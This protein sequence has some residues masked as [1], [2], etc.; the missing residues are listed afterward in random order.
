MPSPK[1]GSVVYTEPRA[2]RV[3]GKYI[4]GIDDTEPH[5][6]VHGS[7]SIIVNNREEAQ[8]V[9]EQWHLFIEDVDKGVRAMRVAM[10][11]EKRL[12]PNG[13]E[14]KADTGT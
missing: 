6:V 14:E 12:A 10:E 8:R 3:N 4:D 13:E 5:S 7:I 9:I 11:N 2:V 1:K